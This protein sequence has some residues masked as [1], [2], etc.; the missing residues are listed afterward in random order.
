MEGQLGDIRIIRVLN[1]GFCMKFPMTQQGESSVP[2]RNG[3]FLYDSRLQTSLN[4]ASYP[5][6]FRL[7]S[8][9]PKPSG[10]WHTAGS[11][12]AIMKMPVSRASKGLQGL[13]PI[14]TVHQFTMNASSAPIPPQENI[15]ALLRKK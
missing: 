15:E 9:F 11:D 6:G 13:Q 5:V 3:S 10:A 1:L 12:M 4:V 14:F 2:K 7:L 8:L